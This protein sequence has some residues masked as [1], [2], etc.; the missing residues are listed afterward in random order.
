MV[1]QLL[2]DGFGIGMFNEYIPKLIEALQ[3][4]GSEFNFTTMETAKALGAIFSLLLAAG[5]AYK[6]M[7]M[8]Q[9]QLDVLAIGKPLLF[10]LLLSNWNLFVNIVS[11][12]GESLEGVFKEKFHQKVIATNATFELRRQT[13][14]NLAKD[15]MNA[16]AAADESLKNFGLMD[17]VTNAGDILA[18]A[19]TALAAGVSMTVFNVLMGALSL[20]GELLWQLGIYSML[21]VKAL[22][23]T[24]LIIF[25]PVYVICALV[26]AW[27]N[28]L[29]DW[30]CKMIKVS[31]IG[32]MVYLAVTFSMFIIDFCMKS[33]ISLMQDMVVNKGFEFWRFIYSLGGTLCQTFLAYLCGFFAVMMA[34]SLANMAF[35][36]GTISENTQ[37]FMSGMTGASASKLTGGMVKA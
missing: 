19:G 16:K 23:K 29:T 35:P 13:A 14:Q 34:P 11:T 30:I 15:I 18:A 25:G 32:A 1:T 37:S 22:Y 31:L 9:G 24:V 36:G 17:I 3:E 33:D 6:V 10:A 21:L 27:G 2:L 7:V 8:Q 26:P 5:Q 20:I 4:A 12:P 28:A